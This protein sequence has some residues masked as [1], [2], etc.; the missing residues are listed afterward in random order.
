[1]AK[2][3]INGIEE[4]PS[5]SEPVSIGDE[6]EIIYRDNSDTGIPTVEPETIQFEPEPGEQRKRRGRPAGSKNAAKSASSR[7]E[8]SQD[9]TAILMGLHM[10]GAAFT[11]IPELELEES[12]AKKLGDA[13][14]RV[15]ELYNGILL[16]DKQRA[17]IGLAMAAGTIYGPRL[18]AHKMRLK[19]EKKGKPQVITVN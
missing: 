17:W 6:G 18:V 5:D 10:M 8:T 16:T 13:L 7:K 15:N 11:K 12:E 14:A 9:L 19:N 4:L 3:R 2:Q 1:M